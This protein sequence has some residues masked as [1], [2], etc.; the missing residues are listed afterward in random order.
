MNESHSTVVERSLLFEK[1]ANDDVVA[2]LEALQSEPS[3]ELSVEQKAEVVAFSDGLTTAEAAHF[4]NVRSLQEL[5][6]MNTDERRPMFVPGY[7]MSEAGRASARALLD[8]ELPDFETEQAAHDY[9]LSFDYRAHA[10]KKGFSD[11]A[12]RSEIAARDPIAKAL[13]AGE[14]PNT[15]LRIEIITDPELYLE[16]AIELRRFKDA[17]KQ[18]RVDVRGQQEF[19]NDVDDAKLLMIDLHLAR[20]NELLAQ[21][22]PGLAGILRQADAG[23]WGEDGDV[24]RSIIED[25]SPTI[26]SSD[27]YKN[28]SAGLLD[29]LRNGASLRDG[30]SSVESQTTAHKVDHIGAPLAELDE[31]FF[32]KEEIDAMRHEV[33]T[34]ADIAEAMRL[35]LDEWGLLSSE[36]DWS[37]ERDGWA[38]DGKW[39]VVID[40][41]FDNH[42]I[43]GKQGI[44]AVPTG[45]ERTLMQPLPA[46]VVPLTDHELE[47]VLQGH[48]ARSNPNGLMLSRLGI[49]GARSSVFREAGGKAREVASQREYFGQQQQ[50]NIFYVRALRVMTEGGSEGEAIRAFYEAA[51]EQNPDEDRM[52]LARTASLSTQRLYRYGG[53]NSQPLAYLEGATILEGLQ[54]MPEHEVRKF[55]IGCSSY[56][57]PDAVRLHEFGLAPTIEDDFIPARTASEILV[58]WVREKIAERQQQTAE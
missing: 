29:K 18:T 17:L 38:S 40:E 53:Y 24:Y 14:I 44:M 54:D 42:K 21:L 13:V 58:P 57:I 2:A 45:Q 10:N 33:F 12:K 43:V 6:V 4:E 49:H 48:A 7:L 23:A 22:Y 3:R 52:K 41:S 9:L 20:V 27:Y 37:Q 28:R 39:Q 47:H 32:T 5:F 36:T 16:K 50:P 8:I 31:A 15:P 30:I 34:E 51:I 25:V 19:G 26:S 46:G 1:R 11:L 35:V 55:M 56:S